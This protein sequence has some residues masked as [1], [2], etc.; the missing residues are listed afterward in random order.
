MKNAAIL[1]RQ[2]VIS[3]RVAVEEDK[4]LFA[5]LWFANPVNTSC[6]VPCLKKFGCEMFG[7][8]TQQVKRMLKIL[9]DGAFVGL[10]SVS[11]VILLGVGHF[12]PLLALHAG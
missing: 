2:E 3:A 9:R 8:G 10:E 5:E 7:C 12:A 4:N 6:S 1:F 11:N